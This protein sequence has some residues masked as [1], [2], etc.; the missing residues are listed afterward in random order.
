MFII[1]YRHNQYNYLIIYYLFKCYL[2]AEHLIFPL[3]ILVLLIILTCSIFFFQ[4]HSVPLFLHWFLI[5][6][7]MVKEWGIS[8]SFFLL[9]PLYHFHPLHI[10]LHFSQNI[11][12]QS[13]PLH[14]TSSRNRKTG[15][16]GF[17][18][19]L[20]NHYYTRHYETF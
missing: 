19:P 4:S 16:F 11:T 9:S 18:T 8:L 3:L 12:V 5:S 2:L 15:A 10:N 20:A 1:F 7:S 13:S 6:T 17:S 14:I